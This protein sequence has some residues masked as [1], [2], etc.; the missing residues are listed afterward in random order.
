MSSESYEEPFFT[1]KQA[2]K[3]LNLKYWA[4]L[5]AANRD[6]FPTYKFVNTCRL[7]RLSEVVAAITC[8]KRGE[9]DG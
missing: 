9:P 6:L 1:L 4:V 7:V 5:K 2:A 8:S 3:L